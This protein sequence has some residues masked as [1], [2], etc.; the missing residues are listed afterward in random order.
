MAER[1]AIDRDSSE[2]AKAATKGTLSILETNKMNTL[3]G[4]I[5]N[6]IKRLSSTLQQI[7][8][9]PSQTLLADIRSIGESL[10]K[11]I[12]DCPKK[13]ERQIL[14]SV[15]VEAAESKAK[16]LR[17]ERSEKFLQTVNNEWIPM[18]NEE[19]R[20][21]EDHEKQIGQ[22]AS[23]RKTIGIPYRLSMLRN[24]L[25]ENVE[26]LLKSIQDITRLAAQFNH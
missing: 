11:E 20:R 4:H 16:Q 23:S 17:I 5:E 7:T 10:D 12:T 25:W 3:R 6:G 1:K 8:S 22:L 26:L 21:I 15:C 9:S 2:Q 13:G 18:L 19:R 24:T 14:D